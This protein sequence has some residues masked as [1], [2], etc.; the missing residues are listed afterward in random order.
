MCM[1]FDRNI[2]KK[3]DVCVPISLPIILRW[4]PNYA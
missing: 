3:F 4:V 2:G 1:L